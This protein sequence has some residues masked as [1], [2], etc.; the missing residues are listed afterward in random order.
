MLRCLKVSIAVAKHHDSKVNW[1]KRVYLFYTSFV[2]LKGSRDKNSSTTGTWRQKQMQKPQRTTAYWLALPG[3]LT[4]PSYSTRPGVVPP[5]II[6]LQSVTTAAA[7]A[8]LMTKC[9]IVLPTG[10]PT[11]QDG[12]NVFS[13]GVPSSQMTLSWVRLT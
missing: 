3:L 4:L 8:D 2:I 1:K 6:P 13:R 9:T 10:L 11:G 7:V 12:R 5:T